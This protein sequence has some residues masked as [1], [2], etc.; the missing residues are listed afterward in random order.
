MS[1]FTWLFAA[2][3]VALAPAV[4]AAESQPSAFEPSR[5]W[6]PTEF[7]FESPY[8][9]ATGPLRVKVGAVAFQEVDIAMTGDAM[10]EHDGGMLSYEGR[11]GGGYFRN[12]LGAEI[13]VTIA[14]AAFGIETEIE[15]GIWD[16]SELA[17]LQFDPYVMPGN[18]V[19]PIT[20]AESIGPNNL[21]DAPLM[22]LGAPA[23]IS[24]D[25]LFEV[26]GIS[27]SGE[28]I[29]VDGVEGEAEPWTSHTQEHEQRAVAFEGAEPGDTVTAWATMRG[30]FDS[31][32]TLHVYPTV[33]IEVLG[34]PISIGPLD[35]AI[36]YP[37][38]TDEAVV[39][40][41]IE[42]QFD[43]PEAPAPEPE[44]EPDPDSTGDDG[45]DEGT[46]GGEDDGGEPEPET[47]SGA[48]T[49]GGAGSGLGVGEDASGCGCT[50]DR[51]GGGFAGLVLL[52]AL[53]LR[54]RR[55]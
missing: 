49:S 34:Q 32:L 20:L 9:P 28:Q 44:P 47:T 12:T 52:G 5:T 4:A 54:R 39:F 42:L 41:D 36:E 38:V 24:I 23:N 8:V 19:R 13:T 17:E 35:I 26:P 16:I 15:L 29:D 30:S 21:V 51:T 6:R 7:P 37:V 1:R 45:G 11:E 50:S 18:P 55:R 33:E 25:Y 48:D 53:G 14:I 22:V 10:Y 40:D 3:L 2:S 31:A 43:I 46:T 27:F